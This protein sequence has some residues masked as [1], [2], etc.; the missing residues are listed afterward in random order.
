MDNIEFRIGDKDFSIP[1]NDE[2]A[3]DSILYELEQAAAAVDGRLME[4]AEEEI[5]GED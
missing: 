4:I 2:S 5:E 3:L 1:A